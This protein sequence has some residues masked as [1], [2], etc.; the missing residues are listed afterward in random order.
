[1]TITVR[2]YNKKNKLV[3]RRTASRDNWAKIYGKLAS[4]SGYKWHIRVEYGKD[5]NVYGKTVMFKNE[6]DYYKLSEAKIALRAF[7][8][9]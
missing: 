2:I 6:G 4:A 8:E 3:A 5:K 9:R 1:M 7:L